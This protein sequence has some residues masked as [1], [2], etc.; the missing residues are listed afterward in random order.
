M[1]CVQGFQVITKKERK[2][3]T[4]IDFST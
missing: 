4:F 3:G 1:Q 2:K